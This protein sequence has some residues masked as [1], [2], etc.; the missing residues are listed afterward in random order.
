M[1]FRN[2]VTTIIIFISIN[3]YSQ[4]T[5]NGGLRMN[6]SFISMCAVDS[7]CVWGVATV[8][9]MEDTT[10]IYK[11]T[12]SHIWYRLPMQN[13][14][15]P[16]KMTCI[17]ALDS[18]RAWVGTDDGKIYHTTN[19]GFNWIQIYSF[20]G[21]GFINDIKFSQQN[22]LV[23]YANSD[24][25][26]G[27]GTP[28]KILKTTNGGINWLEYGPVLTAGYNGAARSSSVT[29]ANHYWFG[30][31]NSSS[32]VPRI[33]YT[34]NGGLNWNVRS[35][36]YN[37]GFLYPVEMMSNSLVGYC[38]ALNY[39]PVY[40]FKTTDGGNS[41]GNAYT[42]PVEANWG[43]S[44]IKH[45]AGTYNWY[46]STESMM[47]V[48]IYK[49]TN[50]GLTWAPMIIDNNHDQ[51]RSMCFT[52]N[53]NRIRGFASTYSGAIYNLYSDTAYLVNVENIGGTIPSNYKLEQNYPNPFNPITKINFNVPRSG[54]ALLVVY[55]MLG[56]EVST[57]VN[58]NLQPGV[59]ETTFDGSG[60]NSGVYFY[61]LTSGDY[62]ETRKMILLK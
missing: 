45:V 8:G 28:F 38:S 40:L 31:S 3:S 43:V 15:Y 1:I 47:N 42:V 5:S 53:G 19:G 62:S 51:V 13:F 56:R 35:I 29:D 57:L 26:N 32:N 21:S 14:M 41:W 33:A 39:F 20:G 37:S 11:F 59:Y 6:D 2:I 10:C 58:V 34:S 36:S 23:G 24:P 4:W 46:F 16:T 25:P 54:R 52:R 7:S 61:R 17:A 30:L 44:S 49:S 9:Y 48:P 27:T 12:P 60:L 18:N 55:D 50:N 22:K